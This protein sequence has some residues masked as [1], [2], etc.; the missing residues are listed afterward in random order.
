[1]K[2]FHE[3]IWPQ[4]CKLGPIFSCYRDRISPKNKEELTARAILHMKQAL[5]GGSIL[6]CHWNCSNVG[7]REPLQGGIVGE[8]QA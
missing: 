1:M 3:A 8:I 2:Y 7:R 4:E 5:F 6:A